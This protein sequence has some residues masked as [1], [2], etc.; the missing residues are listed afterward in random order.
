MGVLKNWW[1]LLDHGTLEAGVSHKWLDES[2]K[3]TELFLHADNDWIIFA[4]TTSLLC[5]FDICLLSIAVVPFP[6]EK[7]S[8]LVSPTAFNKI[9]IKFGKIIFCLMQYLK[10]YGK[11]PETWCSSCIDIETHYFKVRHSSQMVMKNIAIP[12]I[13]FSPHNFKVLLTH[14]MEFWGLVIP[15]NFFWR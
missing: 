9:L 14:C 4:L 5:I 7:S 2:S 10:K 11:W 15:F 6:Q 12:A 3:F 8:N 13:A 1:D